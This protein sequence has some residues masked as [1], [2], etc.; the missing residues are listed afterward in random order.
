MFKTAL[1]IAS[2]ASLLVASLT[3]AS[4]ADAATD[5]FP[6]TPEQIR[7]TGPCGPTGGYRSSEWSQTTTNR[8]LRSQVDVAALREGWYWRHDVNTLWRGDTR[9]DPQAI[10]RSGFTPLG[11]DL[12]PLA[13]WIIGGGGQNS[14]HLSTSCDRWVAQGFATGGGKDGWVYAIQAPGGIDV[15]ATARMT[16]IQSQ[17]L[18]NKEIDFPGGVQGRYI[19]GA[20]QYHWAGQDPETNANIYKNLGCVTNKDFRPADNRRAARALSSH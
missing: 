16:G 11:T 6:G 5:P 14:A 19:E 20:C 15:N 17:Y 18:W 3:F 2:A 4:S 10:F 7:D 1:R 12:T 13:K 8:G 9:P